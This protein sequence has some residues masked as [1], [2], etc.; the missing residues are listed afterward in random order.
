MIPLGAKKW[1]ILLQYG[2][3][4][5]YTS[6]RPLL[7]AR[8][9]RCRLFMAPPWE[10]RNWWACGNTGPDREMGGFGGTAFGFSSAV[11]TVSVTSTGIVSSFLSGFGIGAE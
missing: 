9:G 7:A 11:S 2:L 10:P 3:S 8:P 4:F 6:Y 1:P 5:R